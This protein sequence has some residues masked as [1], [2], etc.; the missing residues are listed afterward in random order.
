M[1]QKHYTFDFWHYA[2]LDELPAEDRR[3]V[4]RARA[5]CKSAYAPYRD[6]G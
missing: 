2:S 3:L 1:E 5:V 6:F 4:E